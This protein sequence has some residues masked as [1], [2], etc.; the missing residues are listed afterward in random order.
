MRPA[1]ALVAAA[2]MPPFTTKRLYL[3]RHGQAMHNPRAEKARAEGCSHDEFLEIMRQD[4]HLDAPLTKLGIEQAKE[5]EARYGH[6]M[7]DVD[8]V[9]SS[10]LSRAVQTADMI[11]PPT[12]ANQCGATGSQSTSD[13]AR[14]FATSS[15]SGVDP[16][17]LVMESL[18]EVNGW[19]LNAKRKSR[20]D[21][22]SDFGPSW[23]FSGL[24]NEDS[25]WTKELESQLECAERGYLSL[26]S[27]A[28]RPEQKMV[29]VSHGG[30]LR[31]TMNMHPSVGVR[32]GRN[33]R[34]A[35]DA[36][37]IANVRCSK[38]RFGNCELRAYEL[39]LVFDKD[40]NLEGDVDL[41]KLRPDV[42][43][44]EVDLEEL[45]N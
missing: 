6:L 11:L 4:D 13:H 14:S 39:D 3:I 17:R 25:L 33:T 28:E 36:E 41:Q 7:Q 27:L 45:R 38:S 2:A 9:V 10:P 22:E 19:L 18:R 16:K 43:L 8:L 42:V 34:T 29:V 44:T 40:Y 1:R 24:E 32:D 23:D 21:L 31:F 26:L 12:E 20:S 5:G 37:G 30:L 35:S 15:S